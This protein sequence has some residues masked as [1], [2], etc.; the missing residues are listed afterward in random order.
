MIVLRAKVGQR[1][2]ILLK[3]GHPK[4]VVG[5]QSFLGCRFEAGEG[6]APQI[7]LFVSSSPSPPAPGTMYCESVS[8]RSSVG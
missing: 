1:R 6:R 7:Q 4:R 5:L 2:V 8:P 3:A